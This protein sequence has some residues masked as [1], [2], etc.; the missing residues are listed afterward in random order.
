MGVECGGGN[1]KEIDRMGK[2]CKG[3]E[4]SRM[5]SEGRVK[6]GSISEKREMSSRGRV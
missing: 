2:V 6:V 4:K 3:K 1:V 5:V